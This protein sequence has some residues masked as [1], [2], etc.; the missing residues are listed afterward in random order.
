MTECSSV[1]QRRRAQS[2]YLAPIAMILFG[3][4]LAFVVAFSAGA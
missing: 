3:L 1:A 2:G 4:V